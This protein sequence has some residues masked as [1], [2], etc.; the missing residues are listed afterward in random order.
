MHKRYFQENPSQKL[1]VENLTL[2]DDKQIF[3]ILCYEAS[4]CFDFL[5]ERVDSLLAREEYMRN[6][7]EGDNHLAAQ[8][9]DK[10]KKI[11]SHKVVKRYSLHMSFAIQSNIKL[12]FDYSDRKASTG[13][14][15]RQQKEIELLEKPEWHLYHMKAVMGSYKTRS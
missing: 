8:A 9:S 3:K 5:G 12:N 6:I 15:H 1:V 10:F 4:T 7:G 11:P 13:N 2:P 14:A